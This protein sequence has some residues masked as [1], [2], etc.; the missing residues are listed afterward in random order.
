MLSPGS[1]PPRGPSSESHRGHYL[2][3]L[4]SKDDLIPVR[5]DLKPLEKGILCEVMLAPGEAD[6]PQRLRP[7]P[8]SEVK[9][10][11]RPWDVQTN[12]AGSTLSGADLRFLF[13][14]R[15]SH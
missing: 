2:P 14:P 8:L 1:L 13:V 6:K 5:S 11:L 9:R 15:A 3:S 10:V 4:F 7:N 12:P